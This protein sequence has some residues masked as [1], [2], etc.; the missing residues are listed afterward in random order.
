MTK[1]TKFTRDFID[2][3][4]RNVQLWITNSGYW[5]VLRGGKLLH[6]GKC[7]PGLVTG[8]HALGY[9]GLKDKAQSCFDTWQEFGERE[10][11]RTSQRGG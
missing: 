8:D 7:M 3:Q 5:Q 1:I 11:A 2:S 6:M 10:T 9:L 4:N